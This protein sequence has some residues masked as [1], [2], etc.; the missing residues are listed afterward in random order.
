MVQRLVLPQRRKRGD[1][2]IQANKPLNKEEEKRQLRK[3]LDEVKKD[4]VRKFIE[5]K[6]AQG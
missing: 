5:S 1:S 3:L 4:S 2:K 6:L